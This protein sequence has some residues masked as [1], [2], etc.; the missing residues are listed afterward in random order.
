LKNELKIIKDTLQTEDNPTEGEIKTDKSKG[1]GVPQRDQNKIP[2]GK[3]I[4][5]AD[6]Q[7]QSKNKKDSIRK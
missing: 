1:N 6:N 3:D 7:R 5:D 2:V 4:L